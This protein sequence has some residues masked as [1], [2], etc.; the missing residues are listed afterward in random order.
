MEKA[1]KI[2]ETKPDET[3]K[4]KEKHAVKTSFDSDEEE[5]VGP[6]ISLEPIDS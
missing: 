1:K 6:I 4:P 3:L 5:K 2:K